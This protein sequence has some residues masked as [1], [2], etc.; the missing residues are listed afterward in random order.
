MVFLVEVAADLEVFGVLEYV[1]L[2]D[3]ARSLLHLV[4]LGEV[5]SLIQVLGSEI[6]T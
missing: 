6:S 5:L 2:Y 1:L 3:C 4:A